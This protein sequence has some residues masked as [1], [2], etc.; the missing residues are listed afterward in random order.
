V[1]TAFETWISIRKYDFLTDSM[2][3]DRL[4]EFLKSTKKN[5]AETNGTEALQSKCVELLKSIH[6]IQTTKVLLF[7]GFVLNIVG[8]PTSMEKHSTTCN[9]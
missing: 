9:W 3:T 7:G 4:Y 1:F 8:F 6:T 2:L 5:L